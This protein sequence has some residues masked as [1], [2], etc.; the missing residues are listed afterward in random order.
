MRALVFHGPHRLSVEERDAP[1]LA[2]G[3]VRI[4]VIAT[5]ICGSDLH[6]YTG[7]NGRR[8]AGQVMGHEFV[9][10]IAEVGDGVDPALHPIDAVV[11]VNPV[12]GCGICAVC[13][14]PDP[15]VCPDRRVIGVDPTI[16]ASFAE[17]IVVP[18]ANVVSFEAGAY[19]LVGALVEPLAVG[20]R[21]ARRGGVT[22]GTAVAVLGGGPI[23][24]AAALGARR[25]GGDVVVTELSSTRR[26]RVADLGFAVVDPAG[27][28]AGVAIQRALGRRPDV[29]IDAV[30]LSATLRDAL[31]LSAIGA[32]IVLV[33]MGAP[34]VELPAFRVSTEERSIV[35]SFCY[36]AAEFADSAA[37]A[38]ANAE[39]L[40]PLI[41]Q[42]VPLDAA[43]TAFEDLAS[44]AA[45]ASK[46]LVLSG[47]GV[48]A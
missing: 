23:G 9:G 20:Y 17:Q 3:E 22:T 34:D 5:G 44:G 37:W 48:L 42:V 30:G 26:Q 15:D 19:L 8:S 16:S 29:V 24:Q 27:V 46:I 35:G 45:D 2:A 21:A 38:A 41:N 4:A 28:D 40:M 33:G 10:R 7:E 47:V 32:T 39:T 6:G 18:A 36:N 13:L 25:L 12:I 1:T 11:T 14:S 43:P 31:T